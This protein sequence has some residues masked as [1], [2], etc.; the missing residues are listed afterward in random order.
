MSSTAS[1]D[2]F[3]VVGDVPAP[4]HMNDPIAHLEN[5]IGQI[6]SYFGDG[7][8]MIKMSMK[9]GETTIENLSI[10]ERELRSHRDH[11]AAKRIVKYS[12][13]ASVHSVN[14]VLPMR[15]HI[16]EIAEL[17]CEVVDPDVQMD[18]QSLKHVILAVHQESEAAHRI[19]TSG[20]EK[21]QQLV[22]QLND[23]FQDYQERIE[24]AKQ[25]VE[26]SQK[27]ATEYEEEAHRLKKKSDT[28]GILAVVSGATSVPAASIPWITA[29]TQ[30]GWV[31]AAVTVFNPWGV[32]IG[33]T[34]TA[35]CV[36]YSI[37]AGVGRREAQREKEQALQEKEKAEKDAERGKAVVEKTQTNMDLA[38]QMRDTAQTHET[39]WDGMSK[40]AVQAA[41]T[42]SQ[43]RHIDP[44]GAR[45]KRFEDKMKT[46]TSHLLAFVQAVDE[47]LFF[48]H[49]KGLIPPNFRLESTVGR[50]KFLQMERDWTAAADGLN[51]TSESHPTPQ[52]TDATAED[53]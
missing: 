29:G 11:D 7:H 38:S 14:Q 21:F 42:F 47:Y 44:S 48:L 12:Q 31:T 18:P 35:A 5:H 24:K 9:Q 25:Q 33:T 43:L 40:A 46:Y 22:E 50:E 17:L 26:D 32:V 49:K 4:D 6:V 53:A 27:S 3:S 30:G 39:L 2:G 1:L 23:I 16:Q 15:G 36:G 10:M 8:E 51:S 37:Y 52:L 34:L 19:A 28:S 20:L 45:R 13:A 41:N